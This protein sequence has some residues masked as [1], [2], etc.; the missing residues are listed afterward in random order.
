MN[1]GVYGLLVILSIGVA[2]RTGAHPGDG[3]VVLDDRTLF[4]V[5]T[6]PIQGA[7]S[8]HAAIWRWS[9]ESGIELAYRSPHG[10]S[11]VHIEHGLDGHI[12]CSER[13]YLGE[14]P[15]RSGDRPGDRDVYVTQLGRLEFDGEIT[16][17]MGPERGRRPFGR[18]AFL[19]DRDGNILYGD[20]YSRLM[21]QYSDGGV[22][23]LEVDATFEDIQLMA[24]GP[25]DEIYVLDGLTIKV[26]ASDRSVRTLDL[27]HRSAKT[28]F[29]RD[30]G[31]DGT[32]IFD[33]IV[34]P[35]RQ[36]FLADWGRQQVLRV[37][38]QG[39]VTLLYDDSGVYAP[40]GLAFRDGAVAVFESL[41]PRANQGIVPR[42]LTL[43]HNG[44]T[45]LIYDY[46][47]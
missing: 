12:Y 39:V 38:S 4:F 36:I 3:L 35:R 2:D 46:F 45:S 21:M 24:W 27:R 11:N 40:E 23:P 10:S 15:A 8:H 34:D 18:A 47:E 17:L 37:S 41:R 33:M 29:T 30:G 13:R 16:W 19:V 25:Q 7:S 43:E 28:N 14:R 6:D 22:E 20:A 42:L 1:K 32:I 31:L 5:A 26:I 9:E 44:E